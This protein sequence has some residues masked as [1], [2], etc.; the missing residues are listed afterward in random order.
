MSKRKGKRKMD[1]EEYRLLS[2]SNAEEMT[3]LVMQLVSQGWELYLGLVTDGA[4]LYQ[5]MVRR[6]E[7]ELET[8]L[9]RPR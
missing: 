6:P 5:W 4:S 2:A 3:R 9:F 8:L 7:D 1:K